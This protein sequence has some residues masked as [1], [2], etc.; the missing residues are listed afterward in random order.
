[1]GRAAF[2]PLLTF[3]NKS[4]P[5]KHKDARDELPTVRLGGHVAVA[6]G[7]NSEDREVQGLIRCHILAPTV[8]ADAKAEEAD[9]DDEGSPE[10]R[11]L[12]LEQAVHVL[13]LGGSFN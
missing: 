6:D 13:V 4:K 2:P 5:G 1:M 3:C 11:S 8:E 9:Q 12:E 10:L 7:R